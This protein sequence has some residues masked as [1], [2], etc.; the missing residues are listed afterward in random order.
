ELRSAR[1]NYRQNIEWKRR[2]GCYANERVAHRRRRSLRPGRVVRLKIIGGLRAGELGGNG[3]ISAR[4][5]KGGSCHVPSILRIVQHRVLSSR[6]AD[7]VQLEH[8]GHSGGIG[9]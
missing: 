5:R 8:G 2:R 9:E 4:S 6:K 3:R 7:A 1:P